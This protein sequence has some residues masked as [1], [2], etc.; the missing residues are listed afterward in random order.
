MFATIG[1]FAGRQ[2]A[3]IWYALAPFAVLCAVLVAPALLRS[4]PAVALGARGALARPGARRA[5]RVRRGLHR[6]PP[7]AARAVAAT[8]QLGAW[9]LQ[10]LACYV[11]LVALGLDGAPTW[12]PPPPCCS[13]ST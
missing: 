9:A 4:A 11:L 1:L 2:Q 5:A 3:L 12:A 7:P 6:V 10:W 13:P 8:A